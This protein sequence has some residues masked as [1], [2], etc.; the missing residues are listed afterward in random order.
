M[1][2]K[3]STNNTNQEQWGT[4]SRKNKLQKIQRLK[5]GKSAVTDETYVELL[6]YAPEE[7]HKEI[8]NIFNRFA[9]TGED[10]VELNIG[11]PKPLKKTGKTSGPPENLRPIMLLSVLR[12]LLTI[13]MI[14]RTWDRLKQRIP[15][16]QSAYQPGRS[17]TGKVFVCRKRICAS[18]Y[19]LYLLLLDMSKAFETVDREILFLRN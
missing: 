11:I 10:T 19:T 2:K 3:E 12:K 8:A 7:V 5:N 9:D 6:K 15:I 16:D 1:P 14:S 13:C 4:N 18:D 17:T